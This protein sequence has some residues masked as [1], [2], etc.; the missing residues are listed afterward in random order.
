MKATGKTI[1]KRPSVRS[2]A[3]LGQPT[4]SDAQIRKVMEALR[5]LLAQHKGNQSA[6][7][8]DLKMS[9]A[10]VN[11]LV[12][13]KNRPSYRTAE[14][15]AARLGIAVWSLLAREPMAVTADTHPAL[16]GALALMGDRVQPEAR[17]RVMAAAAALPDMQQATWIAMLLDPAHG[18]PSSRPVPDR[19]TE[20]P[21][22]P[23]KPR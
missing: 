16:F 23:K 8:R 11:D 15:I 22:V 21:V 18:P 13:G 10:S 2:V 20:I 3:A 14:R 4:L 6:L 1:E 7:A 17:E 19:T 12:L 5:T 9:Q